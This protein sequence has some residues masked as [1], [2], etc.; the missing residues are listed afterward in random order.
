M[1]L[2]GH[3]NLV[4]YLKYW[5]HGPYICFLMEYLPGGS[6]NKYLQGNPLHDKAKNTEKEILWYFLLD[7][8]NGLS[9][10][11][12]KKLIHGDIKPSNMFLAINLN[13]PTV[14]TLKIGDFGL[15]RSIKSKESIKKGD[16][17]YLAPEL[18]DSTPQITTSVDIFSLGVSLYEMATDYTA[19]EALWTRI[20]QN[21]ISFDKMS[22]E[23]KIIVAR[24]VCRDPSLRI[25]ARDCLC[26]NSKLQ[27]IAMQLGIEPLGEEE[28]SN[29]EMFDAESLESLTEESEEE[30]EKVVEPIR[31]SRAQRGLD[32]VRKKLF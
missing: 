30:I 7:L 31:D 13:N 16:G 15:T 5:N 22:R 14:P 9:F 24:M 20:C 11:H 8:L 6:L 19:N 23:L 25:S 12:K 28:S 10:M 27:E 29:E 26:T 2:Q 32:P 1:L 4:Q 18:L 3:P 17:Q 21:D